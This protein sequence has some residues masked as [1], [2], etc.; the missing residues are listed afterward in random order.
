MRPKRALGLAL[1]DM[2]ANS[3]RL[4]PLNAAIGAILVLA[5]LS[6]ITL[7]ERSCSSCSQDR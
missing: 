7:P 3:W 5:C 2:Y 1:R 4:V 6:A